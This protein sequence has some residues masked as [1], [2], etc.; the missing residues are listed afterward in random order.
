LAPIDKPFVRR[1]NAEVAI[2][3]EGANDRAIF[4]A[5]EKTAANDEQQSVSA[6]PTPPRMKLPSRNSCAL[7]HDS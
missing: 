1:G 3:D 7:H 5:S 6:D 2:A 4:P